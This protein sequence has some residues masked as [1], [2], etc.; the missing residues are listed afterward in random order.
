M[1]NVLRVDLVLINPGEAPVDVLLEKGRG[2]AMEVECQ[3]G[4]TIL[5][6][7]AS[8][9]LEPITRA[10]PR[11]VWGPLPAGGKLAVGPF[12]LPLSRS[13]LPATASFSVQLETRHGTVHL[14][15][16]GVPIKPAL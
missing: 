7:D 14:K 15:T 4:S 11:L 6:S 16:D 12:T 2:A 3:F 1:A 10:G 9:N 5:R 13:A 8:A